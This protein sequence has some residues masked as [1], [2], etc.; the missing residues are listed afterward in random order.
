VAISLIERRG[1]DMGATG[2]WLHM[3]AL[4]ANGHTEIAMAS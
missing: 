4:D 1:A 2:R 3:S